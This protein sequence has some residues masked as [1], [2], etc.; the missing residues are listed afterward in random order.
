MGGEVKPQKPYARS[1]HWE[2]LVTKL[3]RYSNGLADVSLVNALGLLPVVDTRPYRPNIRSSVT[4][5][6]VI[7]AVGPAMVHDSL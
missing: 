5:W 6:A 1:R 3:W 7:L 2:S 4:D